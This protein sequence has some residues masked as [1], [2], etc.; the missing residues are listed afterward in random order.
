M[1]CL[2]SHCGDSWL[3]KQL[4]ACLAGQCCCLSQGLLTKAVGLQAAE[5][6]CLPAVYFCKMRYITASW[7]IT[8]R[9]AAHMST[10]C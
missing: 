10:C 7:C 8:V 6:G 9:G 3:P 2:H 4:A 5:S 1:L